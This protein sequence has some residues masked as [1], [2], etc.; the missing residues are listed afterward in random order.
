MS[1]TPRDNVE[2]CKEGGLA[3][4]LRMGDSMRRVSWGYPTNRP[5]FPNHHVAIEG[6]PGNSFLSWI[7]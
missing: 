4:D 3:G 6:S 1:G 5:D 2:R 7:K